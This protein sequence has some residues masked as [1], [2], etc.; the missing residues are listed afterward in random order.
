MGD[1]FDVVVVGAGIAGASVAYELAV[2]RRVLMVEREERPG[3]HSSG[4][5]AA[6]LIASYGTSAVRGLTRASRPFF[7][8][9]PDG[10]VDKPLL[11]ARGY[12]HI[13]RED[14]LGRLDALEDEI[15]P[16]V[17]RLRRLT[18]PEV[19]E[20]A[21]LVDCS[22]VAAGLLEPDA[23]AIDDA[24]LHQGYL[25]GFAR[26]GGK[27]VT[28]ADVMKITPG[29]NGAWKVE[30][31]AGAFEAD[32]LV[33]AAGAWAEDVAILAGVAP[34]GLEPKRRTAILLDVPEVNGPPAGGTP[35]VTDVDDQFYVKPE[36]AALMVSP[37]DETPSEPTDAQPEELDVAIAVDRFETLTGTRVQKVGRR[38]AGLRTFVPD[39]APVIGFDG[40]APG[41]F[42][43]AGQGGFGVMTA[44]GA[45]RL[46]SALMSGRRPDDDLA[47]LEDAVSPA[48]LRK[49]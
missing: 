22:Y 36:G 23:M 46:A 8:R 21:P 10:F 37:A 43:L 28:D 30:T 6:M 26:R 32:V 19:V 12:L 11:S 38:W 9:P 14:Q 31:R 1:V 33:N 40:E 39:H 44:P 17:P 27:L 47:G 42:W 5:S 7:E 34:I 2:D 20:L 29:A 4:R 48:R 3:Y 35:M 25:R 24:A 49:A 41:F 16:H 15:R 45:A 13:A 18:G